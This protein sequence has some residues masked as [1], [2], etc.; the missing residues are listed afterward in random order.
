MTTFNK[1]KSLENS[2]RQRA[3]DN[4]EALACKEW[5]ALEKIHGA[6]FNF[7]V[8]H[9][10]GSS[11]V[12]PGKRTGYLTENELFSFFGCHEIAQAH[13][14][15]MQYIHKQLVELGRINE[16]DRITV[17]GELY[18]GNIQKEVEYGEK[19]FAAYDIQVNCGDWI[20]WDDVV[21]VCDK[22]AVET[23]YEIKR[24]SLHELCE[25]S[26]EFQSYHAPVG[27]RDQSEGFVIKQL[28][29]ERPAIKGG[30][31]AILKVKSEAFKEKKSKTGRT[32]KPE[33]LLTDEQSDVFTDFVPYLTR[34]RINNVI[35]KIGAIS[36][37]DFG[38]LSGMLLA[39]AK[40]EFERDELDETPIDKKIWGVIRNPLMKT[41]QGIVRDH[42]L[43]ILDEYVTE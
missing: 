1:Y 20:D 19:R 4:C 26:P 11:V 22:A 42:W 5:V 10:D 9:E 25:M 27:E 13:I 39:D 28:K 12:K 31:R 6:N 3:V 21:I 7:D 35:S 23:T 29:D 2:Y 16:S 33:V 24:G 14:P 34:N 38:K 18:G 17:Y 32:P 43:D 36:Q 37:K 30:G 15:K 40:S 8:I 41:A